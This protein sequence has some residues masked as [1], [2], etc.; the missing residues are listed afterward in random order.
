[1]AEPDHGTEIAEKI[2]FVCSA[3][4]LNGERREYFFDMCGWAMHGKAA[5]TVLLVI[6]H[7]G[8]S[9]AETL[10]T[11][12]AKSLGDYCSEPCGSLLAGTEAQILKARQRVWGKPVDIACF[13]EAPDRR[14]N[15]KAL[16]R[17]WRRQGDYEPTAMTLVA[18]TP[19]QARLALDSS[20]DKRWA[21][22]MK[23]LSLEGVAL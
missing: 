22:G 13:R 2:D 4:G 20:D 15:R 17:A 12:I 1:M 3:C 21:E 7:P 9:R 16:S 11:M 18:C 8:S 10:V 23:P 5:G 14:W 6:D 19:A